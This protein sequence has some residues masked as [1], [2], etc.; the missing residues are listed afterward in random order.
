MEDNSK[1]KFF[2][3]NI[4][5]VVLENRE[6]F[7]W[8]SVTAEEVVPTY[9]KALS[10][11]TYKVECSRP[12]C[13]PLLAKQFGKGYLTQL[14]DRNIDNQVCQFLGSKGVGPKVYFFN[15]EYRIE[16]FVQSTGFTSE[17]MNDQKMR[18]L[19]T[20]YIEKLHRNPAPCLA[21]ESLLHRIRS[22]DIKLVELCRAS[23]AS[24]QASFDAEERRKVDE[25]LRLVEPD[26][27]AWLAEKTAPF[28]AD[29]V[30]SHNDVLN[31]NILKLPDGGLLLIDF[32]YST[33]NFRMFDVA[34]FISESLFDY[35]VQQPPFFAYFADRRDSDEKVSEM[36]EYYLLFASIKDPIS[37]EQAQALVDNPASAK[38]QLVSTFGSEEAV[39]SEVRKYVEQLHMG[40]LLSHFYWCVWALV[41]CKNPNIDFSYID[42]AY[43][44]YSDYVQLKQ[45]FYKL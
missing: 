8:P 42:F 41:M 38:Q 19:L 26:E 2:F 35:T 20:Y 13:Q 15:N 1:T 14:L 31:G 27:L 9:M 16:E 7:G 17:D 30:A 10:N 34:N 43:I 5:P 22:G 3:E 40:Y 24:K 37:P 29:L 36:M 44:R 32:E 28:E 12:G 45:R 25:V 33:F 4:F 39:Q 23:I 21:P 11:M 6:L 18:N